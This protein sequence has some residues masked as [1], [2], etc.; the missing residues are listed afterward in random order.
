MNHFATVTFDVKVE[1]KWKYVTG[2]EDFLLL[3]ELV[4]KKSS[5]YSILLFF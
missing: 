3:V 1:K 4:Q 2:V 5:F